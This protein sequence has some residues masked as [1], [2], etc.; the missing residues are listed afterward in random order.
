[1]YADIEIA[2][3]PQS[4]LVLNG[5]LAGMIFGVSMGLRRADFI[6]VLRQPRAPVAGLIAQ[7]LLLPAATCVATSLLAVEPALALGMILIASCPG[8]TFSNVMTWLG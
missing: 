2:F 6:R 1:M 3:S 7:F 4:L 5:I 8:G